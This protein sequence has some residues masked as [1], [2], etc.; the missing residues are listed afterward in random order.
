MIGLFFR[1]AALMLGVLFV[2]LWGCGSTEPSRF[3]LLEPIPDPEV[4]EQSEE[5]G[6]LVGVGPVELPKYLDRTQ[7][8]IRANRN[9]LRLA[10]FDRWAEPLEDNLLRILAENLSILLPTNRVVSFPL[11]GR[12]TVDYRV[13]VQ[14]IRFEGGPAGSVTLNARWT[15]L[16]EGG[17]KPLL[18]RKS[19]IT[20]PAGEK[21]NF[22]ELVAAKS[23]ALA[24]LSRGIASAITA[25]QDKTRD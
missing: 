20:R 4:S 21:D 23:L 3:Y 14:L 16:G 11:K 13:Q 1:L 8:V 5:R 9:E 22:V 15:I 7:I 18:V 6:L 24:D 17:N 2:S 12:D 10:E 19:F 25:L